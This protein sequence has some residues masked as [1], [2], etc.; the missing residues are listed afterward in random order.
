MGILSAVIATVANV[1]LPTIQSL[2]TQL[3]DFFSYYHRLE[4]PSP[5]IFAQ[6]CISSWP[7]LLLPFL[8]NR[9]EG[10]VREGKTCIGCVDYI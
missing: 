8:L 1:S 10:E 2:G 4:Q 3:T 9:M 6:H 5:S 7:P